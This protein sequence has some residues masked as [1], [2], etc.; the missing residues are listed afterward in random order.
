MSTGNDLE[1]QPLNTTYVVHTTPPHQEPARPR[2]NLTPFLIRFTLF[3]FLLHLL[4]IDPVLPRV[5][6][7]Y[8]DYRNIP[9]HGKNGESNSC[10]QYES[11]QPRANELLDGNKAI[12]FGEEYKE[13]SVDILAQSVR[14]HTESFDTMGPVGEDSRWDV[15]YT[16][17]LSSPTSSL[18]LRAAR[19]NVTSMT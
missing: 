10:P 1:K 8:D 5:K 12:I 4:L 6:R 14:I 9:K 3:Y 13:Y 17:S 15:F 7:H 11:I 16:V 2:W 19:L 18:A